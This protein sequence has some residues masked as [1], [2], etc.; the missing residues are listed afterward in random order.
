MVTDEER[1]VKCVAFHCNRRFN[2]VGRIRVC[3][4]CR[5]KGLCD[6]CG[7]PGKSRCGVC[8]IKETLGPFPFKQLVMIHHKDSELFGVPTYVWRIK[9]SD[10]KTH[11]NLCEG[12]IE[13]IQVARE[14]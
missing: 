11:K 10:G 7:E 3:G 12:C 13:T 5:R 1:G 4:T 9:F 2:H 8:G 6:S 14:V